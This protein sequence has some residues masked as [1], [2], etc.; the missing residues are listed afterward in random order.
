[1]LEQAGPEDQIFESDVMMFSQSLPK[2]KDQQLREDVENDSLINE[3]RE[4]V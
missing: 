2:S 3:W 1:M 4:G